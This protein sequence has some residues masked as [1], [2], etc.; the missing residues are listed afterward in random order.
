M[1]VDRV[2]G[3]SYLVLAIVRFKGYLDRPTAMVIARVT[4]L[5]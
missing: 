3:A 5:G 1:Q 2:D 4:V